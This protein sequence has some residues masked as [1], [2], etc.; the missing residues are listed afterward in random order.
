MPPPTQVSLG[1]DANPAH[2]SAG[3]FNVL[4]RRLAGGWLDWSFHIGANVCLVGLYNAAVL[5]AERSLF[6]L[7][8]CHYSE[9]ARMAFNGAWGRCSR[10][11]HLRTLDAREGL[12]RGRRGAGEGAGEGQ[13]ATGW[14]LGRCSA[15]GEMPVL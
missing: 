9:Q 5:T 6:F 11:V 13:G 14:R 1:I 8:N 10:A 7:I 4:A 3:Y 15:G 12:A 2:Y